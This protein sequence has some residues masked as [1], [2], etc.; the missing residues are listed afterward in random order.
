MQTTTDRNYSVRPT[1]CLAACDY[2]PVVQVNLRFHGPVRERDVEAFLANPSPFSIE[3]K[4]SV[5]MVLGP[6]AVPVDGWETNAPPAVA[7]G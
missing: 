7:A 5:S 3:G 2:A 6:Q 1:E 4:P